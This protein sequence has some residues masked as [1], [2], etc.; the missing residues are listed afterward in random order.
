MLQRNDITPRDA[1]EV[2]EEGKQE[3]N[4][5]KKSRSFD[6]YEGINRVFMISN[7]MVEQRID[8]KSKVIKGF[9][10]AFS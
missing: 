9:E 3:G 6:A 8:L 7:F 2:N 4:S 10:S 1:K 5:D